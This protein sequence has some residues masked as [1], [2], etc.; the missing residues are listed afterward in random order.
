[1]EKTVYLVFGLVCFLVSVH[2]LTKILDWNTKRRLAKFK[3][4][5]AEF[6]ADLYKLQRKWS[7]RGE[8]DY[9]N[10]INTVIL[11]FSIPKEPEAATAYGRDIQKKLKD[12]EEDEQP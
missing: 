12:L 7:D 10:G 9:G 6:I 8:F 1:M 5:K 2:Y 11:H 4:S 3:D